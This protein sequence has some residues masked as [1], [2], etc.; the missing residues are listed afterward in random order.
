VALL[1]RGGDPPE[2]GPKAMPGHRQGLPRGLIPML[3][4]SASGESDHPKK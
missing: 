2:G 1:A 3:A 4:F